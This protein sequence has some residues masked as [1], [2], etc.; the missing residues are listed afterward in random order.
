MSARFLRDEKGSPTAEFALILPALIML[1]FGGFEAG[2]FVWTQHKLVKAVREGARFAARLPVT[3]Y[4]DGATAQFDP[5]AEADIKA[6][7]LTGAL[8]GASTNPAVPGMTLSNITVS[9]ACAAYAVSETGSGTGI[10]SDLGNGGPVVTVSV[11]GVG[12]PSLFAQLAGLDGSINLAAKAS[13]PVI[14]L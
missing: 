9:P 14:G 12:Y 2:N 11:A 8:P 5:D 7:T 3:D 4:C 10:Y 6:V 13:A 1:M